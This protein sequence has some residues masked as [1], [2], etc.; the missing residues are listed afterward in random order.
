MNLLPDDVIGYN[1]S[2][3]LSLGDSFSLISNDNLMSIFRERLYRDILKSS[4]APEE[5]YI[6]EVL[7]LNSTSL[8]ETSLDV[9]GLV[10]DGILFY[11]DYTAASETTRVLYRDILTRSIDLHANTIT[12][13]ISRRIEPEDVIDAIGQV[14][15]P[16][17]APIIV[18]NDD[19]L[20][21]LILYIPQ[22]YFEGG[23]LIDDIISQ[24]NASRR[25]LLKSRELLSILVVARVLPIEDIQ[26]LAMSILGLDDIELSFGEDFISKEDDNFEMN[27]LERASP[28]VE[29]NSDISYYNRMKETLRNGAAEE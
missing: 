20:R 29:T 1:I 14:M 11:E 12:S 23:D 25:T 24:V 27:L 10:D 28:Y 2:R 22:S 17:Y 19:L 6:D 7:R 16:T 18:D 21:A 3:Y 5:V 15:N 13:W 4:T 8:L 9:H 26:A